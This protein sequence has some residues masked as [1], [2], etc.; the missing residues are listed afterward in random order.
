M[1]GE[2]R[3]SVIILSAGTMFNANLCIGV[4]IVKR[5]HRSALGDWPLATT[6]NT[7]G[8]SDRL[9]PTTP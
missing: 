7:S 4:P 2:T 6:F 5:A 1:L 3:G 8:P 9:A